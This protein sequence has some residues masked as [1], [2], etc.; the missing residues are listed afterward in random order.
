MV[1][2]LAL[3]WC[4]GLALLCFSAQAGAAA[5]QQGDVAQPENVDAPAVAASPPSAAPSPDLAAQELAKKLSN[6]IASLISFPLQ[7]NYDWGLGPEDEGTQF[8]LN[9]QPVIPIKINDD[10]NMISRTILPVVSQ[11]KVLPP[12]PDGDD[13]QFGLGDTVQSLFFS[14]TKPTRGGLIWG[15]GPVIYLPTATDKLLGAQKWGAGPTAVALKQMHGWTV[16]ALANHIWSVAGDDD[17]DDISATF[18]QPFVSY[19]TPKATTL[20]LNTESTYDWVHDQW[21]VPVNVMVAQL[22][23]PKT[24]G[25]PFPIQLQLGYRHYFVKP[26]GGP[27]NGVRF[28]IIAI[29]PK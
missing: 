1:K 23:R 13:D 18:L 29:F 4:M 17:R 15:V 10:W 24:F 5:A 2:R 25:L 27:E 12:S 28:S 16:G 19:A 7:A 6:P 8:R 14:P 22:F 20:S 9:V 11:D 21:T 26:T 3:D